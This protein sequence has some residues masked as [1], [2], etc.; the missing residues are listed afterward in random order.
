MPTFRGL[1]QINCGVMNGRLNYINMVM[2]A[3]DQ[4]GANPEM[5]RSAFEQHSLAALQNSKRRAVGICYT[6]LVFNNQLQEIHGRTMDGGW[7]HCRRMPWQRYSSML[8]YPALRSTADN[9]TAAVFLLSASLSAR[10]NCDA[11]INRLG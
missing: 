8:L 1:L 6:A 11:L 5:S 3:A 10:K 9:R 2:P 7:R 4:P